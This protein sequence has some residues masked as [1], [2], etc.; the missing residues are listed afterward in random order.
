MDLENFS[1]KSPLSFYQDFHAKLFAKNLVALMAFHVKDVLDKPDDTKI[2]QYQ[3]NF[4]QAL[5][6]SKGVIALLFHDSS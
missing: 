2:Y 1:G 3:I 5:A 6:K 4:T